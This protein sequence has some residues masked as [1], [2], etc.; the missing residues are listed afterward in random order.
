MKTNALV[1]C[2]YINKGFPEKQEDVYVCICT[3]IFACVCV[4][5]C[6]YLYRKR[7]REIDWLVDFQELAH[8]IVKVQWVQSLPDGLGDS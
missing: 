1:F 6:I 2:H 7:E 3:F 5:M 8:V 4:C